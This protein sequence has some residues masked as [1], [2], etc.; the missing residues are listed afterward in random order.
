[1]TKKSYIT[2]AF[3]YSILLTCAESATLSVSLGQ[4]T[5]NG[6]TGGTAIDLT[7]EGDTDWGIWQ[8]TNL[9][10]SSSMAGGSGFTSFTYLGAAA[11]Q[12]ATFGN[13]Q[14]GY[15]WTNGTPNATGSGVTQA[16]RADLNA[17]GAGVRLT[18]DVAAAGAYQLKFYTTTFDVNL[19]ATASLVTGGVSDTA[20]GSYVPNSLE[21]YEYTVDFATDGADT[22]NLDVVRSGGG[23]NILAVEAFTLSTSTI[24]EPSSLALLGLGMLGLFSRRRR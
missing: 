23:L 16:A 4:S 19:D 21:K 10:L 15:S 13:P 18:I 22:L 17:V 11:D 12:G 1:M 5:D 9:A 8:N 3:A 2:A 20:I 6:T 14:N 24:P 7:T